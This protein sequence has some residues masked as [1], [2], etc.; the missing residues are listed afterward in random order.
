MGEADTYGNISYLVSKEGNVPSAATQYFT[1]GNGASIQWYALPVTEAS[2]AGQTCNQAGP[3]L[4][5]RLLA[6]HCGKSACMQ[7]RW[8]DSELSEE[9]Q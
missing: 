5:L 1:L 2:L 6:A 8:S 7:G 9:L 3:L 4:S